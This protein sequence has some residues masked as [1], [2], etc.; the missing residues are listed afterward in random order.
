MREAPVA[1]TPA[2][3]VHRVLVLGDS[4]TFGEGLAAEEAF[5]ALLE[6]ELVR[7]TRA[8]WEVLNAG[9]EGYN[10]EAEAAWLARWGMALAPE[11]VIVGFN[12]NDF[13]VAPVV[14]PLGVLTNDRSQRVSSRSPLAHSELWLLVRW[15]V[16]TGGRGATSTPTP[17]PAAASPTPARFHPFDVAVSAARKAWWAGPDDARWRTLVA[18]LVRLRDVARAGGV[19]LVVAILPDGDQLDV[20]APDLRPQARLA[21][22][23]TAERIDCLD[24]HP[25]FAAATERP[26]HFDTM[27][28]D[29]AG[30]RVIAK[31]LADHLLGPSAGR[32]S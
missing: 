4:A 2:A 20:P 18:A 15:L 21:T 1:A 26:L 25:A 9:V 28:P 8:R 27:H 13:D 22:L 7:R 11:T 31:A 24:L 16:A 3:G 29:A 14:G 30:H 17:A 5:P 10:T 12:L 19:R 32:A 6:D 23:C